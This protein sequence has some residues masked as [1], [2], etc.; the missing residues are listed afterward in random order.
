MLP[1]QENL[2]ADHKLLTVQK[3]GTVQEMQW[4]QEV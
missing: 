2:A 4:S 1:N 3:F